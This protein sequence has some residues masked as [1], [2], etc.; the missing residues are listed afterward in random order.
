MRRSHD[1]A[2]TSASST[3]QQKHFPVIQF[4]PYHV[5][6]ETDEVQT[7][8]RIS[9][10]FHYS[11]YAKVAALL[12]LLTFVPAMAF[13]QKLPPPSRTVYKCN[14]A[15]KIVYSDSPCLGAEKLEIEPSRGLSNSS[16]H[17]QL[18]ADVRRERQREDFAEAVKP[19]T[20]LNAKQLDVQGRRLKLSSNAQ[21]EC[22]ALDKS[23]AAS[24]LDEKRASKQEL[25]SI[26]THLLSLRKRYRE[27]GC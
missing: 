9:A 4:R 6:T 24:E 18:G 13:A 23:T 17:E 14:V 21:E 22:R 3:K 26:Q 12:T 19:I 20:G 7:M 10:P 16:G 2:C 15:D 11:S 25:P 8:L 27:L 1:S 5:L